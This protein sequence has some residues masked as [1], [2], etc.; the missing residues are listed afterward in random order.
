MPNCREFVGSLDDYVAEVPDTAAR[1]A[2]V[3][4]LGSC[5]ACAAFLKTY[6]ASMTLGRA[7]FRHRS[8]ADP[9]DVPET[10]VRAILAGS[11]TP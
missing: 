1:A 8:E 3:A 7:V 9:E 6:Q 10:L 11:D 2:F 5:P 4:H